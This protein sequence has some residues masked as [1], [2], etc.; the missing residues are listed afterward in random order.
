MNVKEIKKLA[1]QKGVQVGRLRKTELIRSIQSAE[2]N[3]VCFMTD[4]ADN[5]EETCCLWRPDCR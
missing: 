5:C 4:Q 2:K 1:A 3:P